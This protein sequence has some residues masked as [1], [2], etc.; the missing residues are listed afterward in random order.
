[1]EGLY[2]FLSLIVSLAGFT[3]VAGTL[4]LRG[5]CLVVVATRGV[6]TFTVLYVVQSVIGG[7]F[8]FAANSERRRQDDAT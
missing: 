3:I 7:I 2:R 4:L 8:R 5:E 6:L 1:M